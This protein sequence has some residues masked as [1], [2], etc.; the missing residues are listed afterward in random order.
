MT[1]KRIIHQ[2]LHKSLAIRFSYLC[3]FFWLFGV[4]D[5]LS[6]VSLEDAYG[7]CQGIES[8]AR[9]GQSQRGYL[10]ELRAQVLDHLFAAVQH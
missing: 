8:C 7:L 10:V 5:I 6:E 9:N 1:I 4:L 2:S 3:S